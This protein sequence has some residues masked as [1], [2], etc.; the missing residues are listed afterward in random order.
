MG[1]RETWRLMPEFPRATLAVI[2]LAGHHLGRIERPALFTALFA[3]W[4]ERMSLHSSV[5]TTGLTASSRHRTDQAARAAGIPAA[6]VSRS[7]QTG[8]ETDTMVPVEVRMTRRT[9]QEVVVST[10]SVVD[11]ATAL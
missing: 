4:L 1:F 10:L 11:P 2:D 8:L 3:D 6:G 5:T 7:S 9:K